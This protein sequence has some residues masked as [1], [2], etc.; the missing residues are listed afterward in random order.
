MYQAFEVEPGISNLDILN[1]T[2]N[3]RINK[4]WL[5]QN[6]ITFHLKE[7]G[8]WL[9]QNDIVGNII[10]YRNPEGVNAW[11]PLTTSFLSED[12]QYYHFS[13]YSQGFSTFAIFF[14]KYDCLPNSARCSDNEVQLCLGNSTWLVTDHCADTCDNGKCTISFYKSD[15]FKFLS[16]IVIIAIISIVVI[17]FVYRRR[18][19]KGKNKI[20]RSERREKRIR[21]KINIKNFFN[22]LKDISQKL[23]LIHKIKLFFGRFQRRAEERR[24]REAIALQNKRLE[25]RRLEIQEKEKQKRIQTQQ[26]NEQREK[27]E[28]SRAKVR[29]FF[30][31]LKLI[32]P[33]INPVPKIKSRLRRY[34]R[35]AEERK[36]EQRKKQIREQEIQRRIQIQNKNQQRIE[37]E[38]KKEK[39]IQNKAKTRKFFNSLKVTLRKINPI[40]KIKDGFRKHKIK[41]QE[42]KV[43]RAIALQ[44]MKIE[45]RRIEIQKQNEQRKMQIEAANKLKKER[46]RKRKERAE[47]LKSSELT[48][49]EKEKGRKVEEKYVNERLK[50]LKKRYSL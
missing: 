31:S 8:F 10:L 5:A 47:L 23:N 44:K 43:L 16:V 28:E 6:N 9:V 15:Q 35:K 24:E 36:I 26:Q 41:K 32:I 33:K 11:L 17:L 38:N 45:Q 21:N 25:Q 14:N 40:T 22:S 12:K 37:L 19:K 1:A 20:N 4:T 30:G 13:S 3:F 2:L 7:Q 34:K 42:K 27:R 46:I 48:P 29:K 49:R 39:R 18:K 50:E